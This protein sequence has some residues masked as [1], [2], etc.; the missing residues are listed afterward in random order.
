[1]LFRSQTQLGKDVSKG[2]DDVRDLMAA[3]VQDD[4]DAAHFFDHRIEESGVVLGTDANLARNAIESSACG[5]DIDAKNDGLRPEISSPKVQASTLG[6]TDFQESE[7]S[8]AE[9]SEVA[10]INGDVVVPFVHHLA[11]IAGIDVQQFAGAVLGL[12]V[13][14]HRAFRV[15]GKPLDAFVNTPSCPQYIGH[16][17][18]D[19]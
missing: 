16:A 6:D 17:F 14:F 15:K 11:L 18:D 4:I 2:L 19:R 8:C 1:M 3:V 7:L 13:G 9:L 12:D 10:L 5:V